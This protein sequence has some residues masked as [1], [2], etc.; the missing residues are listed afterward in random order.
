MA[1]DRVERITELID[2]LI[3]QDEMHEMFLDASPWG[4]LVVDKTFHVVYMNR[5]LEHMTGYTLN[6]MLGESMHTLLPPEDHKAHRA[7]E[8]A[9]VKAP[10]SR[11]GNHGLKPRLLHKNGGIINV[12]ISI[13]PTKVHGQTMFFA[14]IRPLET[15]FHTVEGKVIE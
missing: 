12:E 11:T 1:N 4:I 15:L 8:K 9:Y 7:R 6:E 2:R 14:S 3:R 13:S 10:H 5:R